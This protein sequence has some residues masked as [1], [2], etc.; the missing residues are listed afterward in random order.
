MDKIPVTLLAGYLGAGKTTLLNHILNNP[1]GLKIA[2]IVNDLGAV[3][4]DARLIRNNGMKF[5]KEQL[6]ELTNGCICCSLREDFIREIKGLAEDGRFDYI[7]VEASGVSSPV[8]I[9]DAFEE[10]GSK[11]AAG[12][13]SIVAVAD[14]NRIYTE[15]MDKLEEHQTLSNDGEQVEEQDIINLV[16]EQI[17]YS[18]IV[19]INK[20]DL[21]TKPQVERVE[22]IIRSLAPDTE[23]IKATNGCV[24]SGVIFNRKLYH[25]DKMEQ[26]SALSKAWSKG[27]ESNHKLEHGIESF[28]Y[29]R[30]RPFDERK[31]DEWIGSHYPGEII[32]AKGYLWFADDEDH[33]VLFEQAGNSIAITQG[34]RWIASYSESERKELLED[35]PELSEEWDEKTGDRENQIVFIGKNLDI[36][37]LEQELDI[38]LKDR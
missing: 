35:Y 33:A 8:N 32:R 11:F 27:M 17:E 13:D 31:F 19:V 20:C 3:N 10:E 14:A 24:D 4:V 28:F 6:L 36:K 15:F 23:I 26:S 34:P 16:M 22:Q 37:S 1:M 38:C 25:Y 30:P 9:A 5:Q 2:L 29:R 7:L 12:L 18:N 21:L